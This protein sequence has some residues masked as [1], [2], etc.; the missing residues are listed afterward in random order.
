MPGDPYHIVD[1]PKMKAHTARIRRL[2]ELA[3][4]VAKDEFGMGL[5]YDQA[6]FLAWKGEDAWN[7]HL[8]ELKKNKPEATT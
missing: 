4:E 2:M 8:L 5:A 7:E 3:K 1:N 6:L